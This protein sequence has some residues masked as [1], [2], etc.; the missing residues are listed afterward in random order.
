MTPSGIPRRT[1]LP[2]ALLL[3]AGCGSSAPAAGHDP[4]PVSTSPGTQGEVPLVDVFIGTDD[5]DSPNPVPGGKGGSTYPGAALPFGMVQFSPDTPFASPPGYKH[6]DKSIIAFSLTHLDGAGCAGERDLPIFPLT[7]RPDATLDRSDTLVHSR[8][9]ASP[10]FYE[11]TLGSGIK[12]DLT[13]TQRSGFARFT[14]PKGAKQYLTIASGTKRDLLMTRGF[15]ATVAESRLITGWHESSLFCASNSSYKVYFAARFDRDIADH[16]SWDYSTRSSGSKHVSSTRGGLY[17]GFDDP[18]RHAVQMKIGLSY[19]SAAAALTNLDS[20][21]PGWDFDAVHENAID[22]WN[23]YLGRVNVE[24]GSDVE[25]K[26]FYTALYHVLLQPAVASD[27]DGSA[28]GFDDKVEKLAYTRYQNFSGWDIYRSWTQ[29]VSVLAPKETSDMMQS[30]VDTANE[31]GALPR[32]ALANDETGVMV[33]DP[34]DAILAGAYAFGAHG[35]DTKAALSH[36]LKGANDPT[37]RCNN[38]AARPAL[39]DY[40]EL[41]YCPEGAKVRGPPSATL[42]YAV[43]DSAIAQFAGALGDTTN[44][45]AFLDRG[46]YW[47]NVFDPAASANGFSGYVMPRLR[48]DQNGQPAFNE[49]SVADDSAFVEGNAAQYTFMVPQDAYG[50]IQALGGDQGLVT[51]L[52]ALMSKLNAGTKLPNFYMG[53]EPQFGTPWLYA[54]AGRADRTQSVVRRIETEAFRPTPG[55]LPGNDDL[56]ATS[57]WLVWAMLGIYPAVP[58]VGGVVVSSPAFPKA[59]ITL[60]SGETIVITADGAAPDAP[61]V[62]SLTIDGQPTTKSWIDWSQLSGG[63]KLDFKLGKAANTAFGSALGDRPPSSYP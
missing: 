38:H 3:L 53:N 54:F 25:R 18:G 43:A 10:G 32:W 60:E 12:V 42:E 63:A 41:H 1:L 26:I 52:D 21:S 7:S 46:R 16:G 23:G 47:Q 5:S 56:G 61:Y 31:C 58:G 35:F 62:Q 22:T 34:S 28:I 13:A 6:S 14:F 49:V 50:L 59:T 57:S 55:G 17:V 36:M 19:T 4:P 39:S 45:Q 2:A 48:N 9:L 51:R 27:V 40:L 11:V 44:Q 15:E 37:A 24:G 29:L 30:L 8:E 20:G 33:G